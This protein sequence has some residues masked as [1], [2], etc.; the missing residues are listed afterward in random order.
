MRKPNKTRSGI[1]LLAVLIVIIAITIISLSF[2]SRSDGELQ[3][4]H[5]MKLH[6]ELDYLAE[7]GLQHARSLVLNPQDVTFTSGN[8]WTGATAQQ[9]DAGSPYYYDVIVSK[10]STGATAA[11]SFD[12]ISNAYRLSGGLHTAESMLRTE[13]RLDPCIALWAGGTTSLT[14]VTVNGDV[15]CGGNLTNS[16]EITGDVYAAG[17]ITGSAL[18]QKHTAV[19]TPP[20]QWP[21]VTCASLAPNYYINTTAY[22]ALSIDANSVTGY[23]SSASSGNPAGIVYHSGDLILNGPTTITGTLVVT[24]DLTVTGV[25][26][27][28]TAMRNFPALVVGGK[29][30]V[31]SNTNFTVNGL[32]VIGRNLTISPVG[33]TNFSVD[34]GLFIAEGST[35]NPPESSSVTV[36]ADH[37]KTALL[38]WPSSGSHTAW[39]QAGSAF[40]KNLQRSP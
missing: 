10:H 31:E 15:Y 7:S 5:N 23:S 1:A 8:Y 33:N 22:A 13:L 32:A 16:R 3:Y 25:G 38:L 39:R 26:N 35:I 18:G 24:G 4:G 17:S 27:A 6:T 9:L 37:T 34:G 21:G 29:L 11:C 19:A 2:I 30:T 40:F 36:T 28:I 20:V 14:P 12:V